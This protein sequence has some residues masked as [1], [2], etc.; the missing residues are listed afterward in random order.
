MPDPDRDRPNRDG[1][2]REDA[3]GHAA[4]HAEGMAVRRQVLGDEHVDRAQQKTTGFT[5]PFQDFITRSPGVRCGPARR[6]AGR[7]AAA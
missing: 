4:R 3:G 1:P 6:R 7:S 5:A 2:D